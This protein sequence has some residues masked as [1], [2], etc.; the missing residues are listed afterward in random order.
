MSPFPGRSPERSRRF[1]PLLIFACN[2]MTRA[3][4]GGHLV[5][6]LVANLVDKSGQTPLTTLHWRE[7]KRLN[8]QHGPRLNRTHNPKVEVQILH[9]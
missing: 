6:K 5:D 2:V 9:R 3:G 1:I 4:A 7:G 8:R